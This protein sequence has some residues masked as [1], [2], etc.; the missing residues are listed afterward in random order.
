[1]TPLIIQSTPQTPYICCDA[2][3]DVF[4]SYSSKDRVIVEKIC[5][6]LEASDIVCWVAPRDVTPG[7]SYA[8][9]IVNAIQGCTAMLLVFSDSSNG[10]E[11]VGN[12]IDIAFNAK[13]IIN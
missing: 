6:T 11:H 3:H 8:K 9:E 10:S 7:A 5:A 2:K 4:I 13:K 12:E 1:M